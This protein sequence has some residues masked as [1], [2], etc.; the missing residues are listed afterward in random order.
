MNYGEILSGL[1][2]YGRRVLICRSE[3]KKVGVLLGYQI[4]ED[5]NRLF[6]QIKDDLGIVYVCFADKTCDIITRIRNLC[7]YIKVLKDKGLL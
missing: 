6:F 5:S 2:Y 1:P 3:L 7:N 4:Y